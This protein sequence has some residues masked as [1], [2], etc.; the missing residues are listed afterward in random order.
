MQDEPGQTA[1]TDPALMACRECDLLVPLQ[2]T[3]PALRRPALSLQPPRPREQPFAVQRQHVPGAGNPD[4][5]AS[6]G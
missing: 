5:V 3:L 2:R 4:D 1:G 6:P